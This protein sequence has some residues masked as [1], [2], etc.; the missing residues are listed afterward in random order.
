MDFFTWFSGFFFWIGGAFLW[1]VVTIGTAIWYIGLVLVWFAGITIAFFGALIGT[2]FLMFD[3]V[4]PVVQG[5]MWIVI[6]PFLAFLFFLVL[7]F[8]R[9]QS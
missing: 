6:V 3:G 9:G 4:P 2:A 1:V 8:L 5:V 7:R